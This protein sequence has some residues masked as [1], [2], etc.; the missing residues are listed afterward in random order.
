MGSP[1]SE[2]VTASGLA[3]DDVASIV[4][5]LADGQRMSVPLVDNAYAVSIARSRLPARLVAYDGD[6]RVIG[7]TPAITG[8]EAPGGRPARGRARLLLRRVSPTG[9]TAAVF[10]GKSTSG[11]RCTYL[12]VDRSKHV[13]GVM[14]SCRGPTWQGSPLQLIAAEFV[15]GRVRP[16]VA[17]VVIRFAD[18]RQATV[19]PTDG[20]VL[21]TVPRGHL[22][23]GHEV[24]A[25]VARNA[26]GGPVGTQSFAPRR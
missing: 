13:G 6:Q 21:Y 11:G 10:V 17:T 23:R 12:R 22:A 14:Q 2:F 16:D 26:A 24:V 19:V 9:A 8:P 7:F 1:F 4:A 15:A 18:G 5:F 20:F 25:A 3:S